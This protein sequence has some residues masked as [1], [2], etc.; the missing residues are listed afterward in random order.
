MRESEADKCFLRQVRSLLKGAFGLSAEQMA[1]GDR[2]WAAW[3]ELGKS[4]DELF[5]SGVR[6]E[7]KA[8]CLVTLVVPRPE[9]SPFAWATPRLTSLP[10]MT[11]RLQEFC[12][13]TLE[14]LA[15]IKMAPSTEMTD[16]FNGFILG[17]LERLPED[18]PLAERL[19][20]R[21]RPYFRDRG[22]KGSQPFEAIMVSD[23]PEKWKRLA[24]SK[25]RDEIL[26]AVWFPNLQPLRSYLFAVRTAADCYGLALLVSQ[27]EFVVGLSGEVVDED[28]IRALGSFLEVP[29]VVSAVKAAAAAVQS[30]A[31]DIRKR[32][33]ELRAI[34][35][36]RTRPLRE[37]RKQADDERRRREDRLLAQMM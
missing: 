8:R 14:L 36:E 31:D 13:M 28:I 30:R 27:V 22:E 9:L 5:K 3:L 2:T 23:V 12:L 26:R 16:L 17:E 20:R 19:A 29:A 37:A 7:F 15:G 6:E 32:L 34:E 18:D 25:M 33:D 21:Y 1:E 4:F 11:P 24:D 35:Y 10:Q